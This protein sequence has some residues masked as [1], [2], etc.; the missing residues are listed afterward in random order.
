MNKQQAYHSFWSGYSI[1]AY[2][3]NS[4]PDGATMPYITYESSTDNFDYAVAL[5]ASI[6]YRSSSWA[7]IIDKEA[8]ISSTITAGGKI[9]PY[10]GGALWITRAHPWARRSTGETDDLVRRIIL[11][12]FVEFLD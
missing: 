6:W 12:V 10:E 9:V 4:V 11:N 3:E 1:P 5:T 8:T 2:E 7:D